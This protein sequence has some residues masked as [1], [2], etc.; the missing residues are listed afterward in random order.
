MKSTALLIAGITPLALSAP[1]EKRQFSLGAIIN[2]LPPSYILHPL[3]TQTTTPN[4]RKTA[5]RKLIRYGPFKLAANTGGKTKDASHNHG[6]M[7]GMA[8]ILDILLGKTSMDPAGF[9]TMRVLPDSMCRDCTVLAGKVDAVFENGTQAS[10]DHGVYLHHAITI[11]LDKKAPNY[12]ASPKCSGPDLNLL[13]SM[14]NFTP[15]VAGG[16]VRISSTVQYS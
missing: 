8:D 5:T 2:S 15:F 4:V 11:D 14:S 3:V 12:I 13:A 7:G 9:T 1:L 16:V 10:F 6:S